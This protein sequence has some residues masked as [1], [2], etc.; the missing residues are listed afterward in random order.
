MPRTSGL[1]VTIVPWP[2]WPRAQSAGRATLSVVV[3]RVVAV[4]DD[5]KLV[6]VSVA[7][8]GAVARQERLIGLSWSVCRVRLE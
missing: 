5:V 3:V 6:G 4:P 2:L 1:L 7:P 8:V